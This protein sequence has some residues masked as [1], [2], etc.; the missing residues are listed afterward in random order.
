MKYWEITIGS[1]FYQP[2]KFNIITEDFEH[3]QDALDHLVNKMESEGKEYIFTSDDEI[4]E[5]GWGEDEYIV[6]GNHCRYVKHYGVFYIKEL[7]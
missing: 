7:I 5:W 4:N 2:Y 3:E 6:G 1:G